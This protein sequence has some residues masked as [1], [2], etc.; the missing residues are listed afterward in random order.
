M[1]ALKILDV[2]PSKSWVIE[3]SYAGS[4]SGLKAECHLMILTKDN[5]ILNKLI[6]EIQTSN[7]G[8]ILGT[9]LKDTVKNVENSEHI[10]ATIDR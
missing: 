3:D 8:G 4:I 5:E 9:K 1:R 10:K 2:N 7:V 6:N